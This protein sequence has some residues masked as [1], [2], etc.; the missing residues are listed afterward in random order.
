MRARSYDPN[1]PQPSLSCRRSNYI[2]TPN[3]SARLRQKIDY[4]RL[5]ASARAPT[6]ACR[7]LDRQAAGHVER[8]LNSTQAGELPF[9]GPTHFVFAINMRVAKALGVTIR[10]LSLWEP[11][12]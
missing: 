10:P 12:R 9:Q 5:E 8:I 7:E 11:T 3:S 1:S 4:R 6:Q 2:S